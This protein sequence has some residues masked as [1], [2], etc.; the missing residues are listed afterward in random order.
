M[1]VYA[2]LIQSVKGIKLLPNYFDTYKNAVDVVKRKYPDWDDRFDDDNCAKT[3][4]TNN[5]V[6]VEEGHKMDGTR[7]DPNLTELYIEK[8]VYISI[9]RLVKK[10]RQTAE[11]PFGGGYTRRRQIKRNTKN[12]RKT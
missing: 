1:N 2:I 7:G 6:E 11:A 5:K 10:P 3:Y 9:R 12:S 8:E 4:S